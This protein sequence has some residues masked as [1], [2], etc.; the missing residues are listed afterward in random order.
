[1]LH[2]VVKKRKKNDT[3]M[4][5]NERVC[6]LGLDS[7]KIQEQR[8]G[9]LRMGRVDSAGYYDKS[10]GTWDEFIFSSMYLC[11]PK[12][13]VS[14]T[15]VWVVLL[16]TSSS[17]LLAHFRCLTSLTRQSWSTS[18]GTRGCWRRSGSG[19]LAMPSGDPSRT[20]TK[21]KMELQRP[22]FFSE[23]LGKGL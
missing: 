15:M 14:T 9:G 22:S 8:V 18:C 20:F 5:T 16:I 10:V 12:V 17:H 23:R 13:Y 19:K 7:Q 1:M 11:R 4:F 6:Y 3:D 21:G 2:S